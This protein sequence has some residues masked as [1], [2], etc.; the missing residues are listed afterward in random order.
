MLWNWGNGPHYKGYRC[1][2]EG[3]PVPWVKEW[4]HGLGTGLYM[5]TYIHMIVD[6]ATISG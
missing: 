3:R 1:C 5:H 6:E 2:V 4:V